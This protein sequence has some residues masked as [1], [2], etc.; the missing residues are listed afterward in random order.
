MSFTA[1]Y[2]IPSAPRV[3][4]KLSEQVWRMQAPPVSNLRRLALE[5]SGR[6]QWRETSEGV[7]AQGT[8][9][10]PRAASHRTRSADPLLQLPQKAD[11]EKANSER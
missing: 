9:R 10:S 4:R 11:E 2:A 6:R 5:N 1:P 8:A 7:A 3:R